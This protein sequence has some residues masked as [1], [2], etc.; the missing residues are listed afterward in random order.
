MTTQTVSVA[1]LA[2]PQSPRLIH[3]IAGLSLLLIV[4]GFVLT[5]ATLAPAINWPASLD[6]PASQIL[7]LLLEQQQAIRLGY[8][9]YLLS[10]LLLIPAALLVQRALDPG[11]ASLM[12]TLATTFGVL[13]GI[14]RMLGIMRWLV[15]MPV[16]AQLYTNPNADDTTRQATTAAYQALNAYAGSLGELLGVALFGGLWV[17]LAS[18]VLLRRG[19]LRVLAWL[20]VGAG[21]V[22]LLPLGELVGLNVGPATAI[23]NVVWYLWVLI[24]G[25]R[26]LVARPATAELLA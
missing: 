10:S 11:R 21:L 1:P 4:A 24:L 8:G 2:R 26:L 5:F 17:L 3:R 25:V 18:T 15:A 16:L 9:S 19:H 12:L 13:A 23:A 20:G 14:A 22:A 7:P 6:A